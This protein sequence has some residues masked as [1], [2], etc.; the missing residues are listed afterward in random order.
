M[1]CAQNYKTTDNQILTCL[2]RKQIVMIGLH[3]GFSV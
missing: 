3:G 1:Q 2:Q